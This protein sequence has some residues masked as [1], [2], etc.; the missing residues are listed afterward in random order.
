MN[1]HNPL[2]EMIY[3]HYRSLI[4]SGGLN[5]GDRL[6]TEQELQQQFNVSRITA[7][8]AMEKLAAGGFI[9][10]RPGK[11]SFVAGAAQSQRAETV[12][13]PGIPETNSLIGLVLPEF[14]ES[15]GLRL[16]SSMERAADDHNLFLTI[17]RSYGKQEAEVRAI[18]RLIRLGVRGLII[19]PVNGENYNPEILRLYLENFPL[20]LVDKYLPGVPVCSVSTDNRSAAR[21]LTHYLLQ[22]GHRHIGFCS[23]PPDNTVTLEDRWSG[24]AAALKEA[25]VAFPPQWLLNHL[26]TEV[27]TNEDAGYSPYHEDLIA[28]YLTDNP[29]IT[30]IV[31]TEFQ[32]AA[33]IRLAARQLGR[34]VP[35]ELAI[36]CFDS[37]STKSLGWQFTHMRQDEEQMGRRA[38]DI[39]REQIDGAAPSSKGSVTLPAELIHGDSTAAP[40]KTLAPT[41]REAKE[42]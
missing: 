4:T 12:M 11:G 6:P 28:Q 31:A 20:V 3:N 35:E 9:S 26:P 41:T 15:Y 16:L 29:E 17:C 39:L 23:P 8:K 1:R 22:L 14:G 5:S 38:I 10:R 34:R 30:A 32:A 24:F 18:Q 40:G 19:F 27:P 21:E 37:P 13:Q 25:E 2:Y 42:R 7:Q 36:A 33:H